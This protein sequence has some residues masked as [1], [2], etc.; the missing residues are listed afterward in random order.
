MFQF[1]FEELWKDENYGIF[2]SGAPRSGKTNLAFLLVDT[3]IKNNVIVYVFDPTGAQ[4]WK[5]S[6][7]PKYQKVEWKSYL[8]FRDESTGYDISHLTPTQQ[9]KFVENFCRVVFSKRARDRR[10]RLKTF[11]VFEEAQNYVPSEQQSKNASTEHVRQIIHV[12][13]N[14]N[15]RFAL[16]TQFPSSVAEREIKYCRLR[17]YGHCEEP[18]DIEYLKPLLKDKVALL[19]DLHK[20]EFVYYC[21]GSCQVIQVALFKK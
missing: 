8:I 2:I 13:G 3:L 21:Q 17:F 14:I 19:R 18:Q 20:G 15:V 5:Q 16:I 7:I 10:S 9:Q 12:G 4:I 11:L 1:D 6:S